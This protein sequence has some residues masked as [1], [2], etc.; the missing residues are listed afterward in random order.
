VECGDGTFR[1]GDNCIGFDP[2]DDT[3]PV[4]TLDP[5]ASRSR[6]PIPTTVTLS[7]DELSQLYITT[8]GS[9]PDPTTDPGE[10][11][12][13]TIVDVANGMTVKYLAIDRAG[14]QS[15]LESATYISD[16][17]GPSKV[18][19]LAVTTTGADATITWTNPA[20]ADFEG[21]IVAR[22]VDLI[23]ASPE[24]G[25]TY[26]AA[27]DLTPSLQ[28]LQVGTGTQ[29]VDTARPPGRVRYAVWAFD[30]LKNY[31]QPNAARSQIDLGNLEIELQ[32]DAPNNALSVLA[33]SIAL[34]TTGTTATNAAGTVTL[35]LQLKNISTSHFQNP[36][37]LVVSTTNAT[38]GTTNPTADGLSFVDLGPAT[39]APNATITKNVVFTGV[40]GIATFKIRLGH[41]ASMIANRN[42]SRDLA[43]ID[44]G[45]VF[46]ANRLRSSRRS[47]RAPATTARFVPACSP[48]STSSTSPPATARS[49]AGTWSPR[50][51]SRASTSARRTAIART[52]RR[53]SPTRRA[54]TASPRSARRATRVGS[55]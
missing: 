32:Y 31:S 50:R 2:D 24:S 11:S 36:K 29:F 52:S 47:R 34:D 48:A 55:R 46:T 23:D 22:V 6:D 28:I 25:Q 14:N 19:D 7:T 9:D 16:V 42:R 33:P 3:P 4:I 21:V 15:T 27:T 54:S 37:A 39:F 1:D 10:P 8:D 38:F 40:T 18:R 12:P 20:D 35:A 51:A 41:H 43:F 5:P 53:C 45:A 13:V 30:D 49:S 44:S 26:T 17:A